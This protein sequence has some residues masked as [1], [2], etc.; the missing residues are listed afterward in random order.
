MRNQSLSIS[1]LS[2]GIFLT[3]LV[4]PVARAE[5]QNKETS[6]T[7]T[8]TAAPE[9]ARGFPLLER[10]RKAVDELKLSDDQKSKIDTMF[11]EAKSELKK[12]REETAGDRE[13]MLKKIKGVYDKL[14]EN[15][16][17]VLTDEQ[18]E[19]FKGRF[20]K[21]FQRGGAAAA[22]AGEMMGRLKT[23]IE[24]LGL[25]D[26]QKTKVHDLF[27]ET[28][29]KAKELRAQAENGGTDASEKLRDL[30]QETR[31]KLGSILTDEQKQKLRESLP[32]GGAQTQEKKPNE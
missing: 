25:S 20:Q 16:G 4:V 6:T 9:G 8:A 3:G 12:V 24:K 23:A 1:V 29:K 22:G 13:G 32:Q 19:Q 7:Q 18:K 28:A 14:R 10:V 5:D 2:A 30:M 17:G 21:L 15:V 11:E 31:E 27:E 26:E